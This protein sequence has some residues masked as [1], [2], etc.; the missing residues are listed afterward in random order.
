MWIRTT[1]IEPSS[2]THIGKDYTM[3]WYEKVSFCIIDK[4]Y[5][6]S[7]SH[8]LDNTIYILQYLHEGC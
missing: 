4:V 1:I 6:I 2:Y 3:S 8:P 7:T 5:M